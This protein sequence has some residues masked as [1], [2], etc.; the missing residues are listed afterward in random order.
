LKS[1]WN[2]HILLLYLNLDYKNNLL[3]S[4]YKEMLKEFIS[5]DKT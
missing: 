5:T 4:R 2:R 3:V 1:R